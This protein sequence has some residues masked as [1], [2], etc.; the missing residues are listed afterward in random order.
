MD[1]HAGA[2]ATLEALLEADRP[3]RQRNR[4]VPHD[5][6]A[7]A[8]VLHDPGAARQRFLDRADEG[9]HQIDR[10]LLARLLGEPHEADEVRKGDRDPQLTESLGLV[11]QLRLHVG[12]HVLLDEVTQE[13]AMQVDHQRRGLRKQL[14]DQV[15]ELLR[16]LHRGNVVADQRLVHVKAK[17]PR[18][19][20]GELPQRLAVDVQHLEESHQR[21]AGLEHG[22]HVPQRFDVLLAKVAQHPGGKAHRAPQALDQSLLEAGLGR[23]LLEGVR[24]AAGREQ[25]VHIAERKPAVLARLL[26]R[27]QGMTLFAQPRD[28]LRMGGSRA[29]PAPAVVRDHAGLPPSPQGVRGDPRLP[30]GLRQ[31]YLGRALH[32]RPSY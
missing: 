7:V 29:R 5:H 3:I 9:L 32:G 19:G 23:H 1:R 17:Q 14:P 15:A 6:H 12:D 13:V 16:H 4:V 21:E 27:L 8:D 2:R 11:V 28:D 30:G 25:L 26:D 22:G 18:F 31:R 10:L 24:P 20:V